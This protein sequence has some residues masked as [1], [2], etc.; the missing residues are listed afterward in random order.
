[1]LFAANDDLLSS[2]FSRVDKSNHK[3]SRSGRYAVEDE[4]Q[5]GNGTWNVKKI[6]RPGRLPVTVMLDGQG[7]T[8]EAMP[9][10]YGSDYVQ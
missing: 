3:A 8:S 6:R 9:A 2:L 10:M 5:E 1:M 7:C 4:K